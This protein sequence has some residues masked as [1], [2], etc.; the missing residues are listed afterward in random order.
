MIRHDWCD[1]DA[2]ALSSLVC[3]ALQVSGISVPAT[4]MYM[5][6]L[7]LILALFRAAC[8]IPC[9]CP[10]TACWG[11]P[12]TAPTARLLRMADA[13]AGFATGN[14]YG[15]AENLWHLS[16]RRHLVGIS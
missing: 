14:R 5:L 16:Q 13:P 10:A 15:I 6:H 3:M 8:R 7:M 9:Y 4:C 11:R 2:L 12:T 1:M